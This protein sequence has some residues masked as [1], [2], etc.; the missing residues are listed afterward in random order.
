[1]VDV[2]VHCFLNWALYPSRGGIYSEILTASL[3]NR[4]IYSALQ[5][6]KKKNQ[7]LCTTHVLEAL[8]FSTCMREE[9][10]KVYASPGLL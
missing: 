3:K 9:E 5:K 7:I 8:P 2:G 6:K 4:K 10:Q 1:M